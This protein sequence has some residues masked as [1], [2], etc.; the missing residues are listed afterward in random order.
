MEKQFQKY[1]PRIY[2]LDELIL[3][4]YDMVYLHSDKYKIKYMDTSDLH[5][6]RFKL[7]D[8]DLDIIFKDYKPF[9]MVP[10]GMFYDT[11]KE[12]DS[13]CAK[14]IE[15][16]RDITIRII[17][18]QTKNSV[19]NIHDPVNVNK[20]IR[21]LFSELVTN[22]KTSN[23][24][25][26]IINIDVIGSDLE[27]YADLQPYIDP[28]KFYSIELTEHFY[29]IITLEFFLE[30]Y[31]VNELIIKNFIYKI[32]DALY[33]INIVYPGFK[34]NQLMPSMIDCYL[35]ISNKIVYPEPKL[36]NF[37]LAEIENFVQN[38]YLKNGKLPAMGPN[39]P[40]ND[41]YQLLNNLW[42]HHN[43]IIIQY[44][45][46][47]KLFDEILPKKI[48]SDNIYL[49]RDLWNTLSD[50]EKYALKIKNIRNNV[51][52]ASADVFGEGSIPKFGT[53]DV[54]NK[55]SLEVP[56]TDLSM[57]DLGQLDIDTSIEAESRITPNDLSNKNTINKKSHNNDIDSMSNKKKIEKTENYRDSTHKPSKIIQVSESDIESIHR[58]PS[59]TQ[60]VYHGHRKINPDN[61]SQV[62][63][64][65]KHSRHEDEF[66]LNKHH[67]SQFN[68]AQ[69]RV[70]SLG[71]FFGANAPINMPQSNNQMPYNFNQD[72]MQNFAM[73]R[74]TP[75]MNP[76]MALPGQYPPSQTDQMPNQDMLNQM[77]Q[78]LA[79]SG[80]SP[81]MIQPNAMANMMQPNS[82]ANMMPPT[83]TP[84][85]DP[86]MYQQ[87]MNQQM[88]NQQMMQNGQSGGYRNPFF[89][90]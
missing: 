71:Q 26:P 55:G 46:L 31:P 6:D 61:L 39:L 83:Q 24:M 54:P 67:Q 63:K 60:K 12:I 10:S 64:T 7:S 66:N 30:K 62:P 81:S 34:C 50:D 14:R 29:R 36:Y 33:Q 86:A 87:M 42:N 1:H 37:Y 35:K 5:L 43:A 82:M 40:Y 25:L 11:N 90:H 41:I 38:D 58:K 23:I 77:Q 16:N 88:M 32:A 78:Y 13:I 17:E 51:L 70:N 80:N 85:I 56:E 57:N 44:L 74:Q 19:T 73:S 2:K 18:Y 28:A 49:T 27:K 69:S 65:S 20:I 48:R 52:L 15:K 75:A 76:E 84:Q 9:Q 53:Q 3:D 47:V 21:T 79:A 45:D 59:R 72:Q 68:G 89:F 4:I 22:K 8:Y